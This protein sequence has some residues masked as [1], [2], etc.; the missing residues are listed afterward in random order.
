M[1]KLVSTEGPFLAVG[2]VNGDGLDD[3]FI[4]GAKGQPSALFIQQRDGR[5][6]RS[7]DSG[8]RARFASR[9]TSA[10]CSSTPTATATPICTS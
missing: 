7:N 10:R 3:I 9:R 8:V 5:F 2:D 6:A 1:P 4:G